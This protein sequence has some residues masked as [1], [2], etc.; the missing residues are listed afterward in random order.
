MKDIADLAG[1]SIATVSRVINNPDQVK[2]ET[3]E[4]VQK[5]LEQTNFV[6]NAVARG[7]V[8]N[9]MRTIGV[10][11]VDIRDM[12]FARVI[13]TIERGFKDLG[14]NVLLSNTGGEPEEKKGI[15]R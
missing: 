8:I 1:V 12:F 6:A 2:P 15:S 9:S 7:L 3:R 5:I 14:Y 10:L 11:T 4:K 13:Y